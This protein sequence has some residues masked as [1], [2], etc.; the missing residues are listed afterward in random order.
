[1]G[2][3][4]TDQAYSEVDIQTYL[5]YMVASPQNLKSQLR[6]PRKNEKT[7]TQYFKFFNNYFQ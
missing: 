7:K 4:F 2:L 3:S 1:M 5:Y 6:K